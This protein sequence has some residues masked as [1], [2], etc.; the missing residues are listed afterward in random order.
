MAR[1]DIQLWEF[2]V[3]VYGE[4]GVQG[5]CLYLQDHFGVDVNLLLFCACVGSTRCTLL[6]LDALEEVAAIVRAWHTRVVTSLRA[7]RR[8]L[9]P[10]ENEPGR[11]DTQEIKLLRST[12]MAAELEAERIEQKMLSDWY[13]STHRSWP[14]A[15]RREA[16]MSNVR[17]LLRLHEG[18]ESAELPLRLLASALAMR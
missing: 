14:R 17:A 18:R 3:A 11:S 7:A 1:T 13:G 4:P 15:E 9:K 8:A 12:V 2:S 10:Y 16:T 5:E 6:P